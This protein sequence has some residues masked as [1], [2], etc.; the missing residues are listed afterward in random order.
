MARH[1]RTRHGHG[2]GGPAPARRGRPVGGQDADRRTR[3]QPDRGKRPLW[4]PGQPG[5]SRP[6]A[7]RVVQRFGV[8]GRGRAGRLRARHRLRRL[9]EAPGELLRDF[10]DPPDGRPG[11]AR[12][13]DPLRPAFR[14]RR[15][16]RARRRI[17]GNRRPGAARRT[18]LAAA[19]A[20]AAWSRC[21]RGGGRPGRR[22]ARRRDRP[23]G[24]RNRAGA[25]A[26]RWPRAGWV[27]G[28]KPSASCRAHRSGP[29][30]GAG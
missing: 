30:S 9:G 29:I 18:C 5:G 14:C 23:G 24:G 25:R 15:L 28:S 21:L 10:R 12:R 27:T 3:L 6:R 7:R 16:V 22:G 17:A 19:Q 1:P 20:V 11:S 4:N 26:S 13:R 2:V 8:G